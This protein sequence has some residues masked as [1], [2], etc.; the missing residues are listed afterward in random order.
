MTR[1]LG[2]TAVTTAF[3]L[4]L[5]GVITIVAGVRTRRAE[6]VRSGRAAAYANFA[7]LAVYV[8]GG[9]LSTVDYGALAIIGALV[10][11]GL[12]VIALR[13]GWE[14]PTVGAIDRDP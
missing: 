1:F 6:L 11:F 7:L 8:K 9:F 10:C 14:L 4:S 5:Y 2:L 3:A 13:R 12:R